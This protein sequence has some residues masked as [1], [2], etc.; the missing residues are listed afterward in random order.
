L[1]YY[2]QANEG[3]CLFII[4]KGLRI[5]VISN[6]TCKLSQFILALK[7]KREEKTREGGE[8]D[9]LL[10]LLIST[11]VLRSAHRETDSKNGV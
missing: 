7:R 6:D 4:A 10:M 8:N 2:Q 5:Y 11:E 9:F 3:N 1:E